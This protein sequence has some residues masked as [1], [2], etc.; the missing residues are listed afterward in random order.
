[1]DNSGLITANERRRKR[2][3]R[4]IIEERVVMR[5][6]LE[7]IPEGKGKNQGMVTGPILFDIE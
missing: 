4:E 3:Q 1:M 7:R 2:K 6:N 5:K